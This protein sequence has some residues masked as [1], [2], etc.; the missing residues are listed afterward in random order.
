MNGMSFETAL[1]RRTDQM[2]DA[3]VKCGKCV[4]VCP[5]VQP[6]NLGGISSREVIAGVLEIVRSGDGPDVS[7]KWAASCMLSGE[8]IKACDYGV[9][10]RFLLTMARLALMRDS[11][12]TS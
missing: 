2:L 1:G 4:D 9:N 12:P 10:P 7:H 8:C 6:A 11:T 3:C 5:S